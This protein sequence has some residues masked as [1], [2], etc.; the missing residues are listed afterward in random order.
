MTS[1][2]EI[3]KLT[4]LLPKLTM[5]ELVAGK[6]FCSKKNF[7]SN[8]SRKR[9]QKCPFLH[10]IHIS[11]LTSLDMGDSVLLIFKI[12]LKN[13]FTSILSD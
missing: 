10:K 7:L 5:S 6:E 3:L 9:G 1:E 12:G 8:S 4:F 13:N 2:M 11:A